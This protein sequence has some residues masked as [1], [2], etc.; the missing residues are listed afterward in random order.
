MYWQHR[1]LQHSYNFTDADARHFINS[2]GR[3]RKY[4][5][6]YTQLIFQFIFIMFL[7]VAAPSLNFCSVSVL[8]RDIAII[9]QYFPIDFG[10]L[11]RVNLHG[12][13]SWK[14]SLFFK[15]TE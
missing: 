6:N 15:K 14:C 3:I 5:I 12:R 13:L 7:S 8:C 4:I 11:R 10:K 2:G 9:A 1:I